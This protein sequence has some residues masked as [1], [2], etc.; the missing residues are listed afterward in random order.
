MVTGTVRIDQPFQGTG[1]S[2][3]SGAVVTF[4]PGA[5]SKSGKSEMAGSRFKL[6]SKHGGLAFTLAKRKVIELASV[7]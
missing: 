3:V 4:E 2:R 7:S 5:H 1:P 6:G